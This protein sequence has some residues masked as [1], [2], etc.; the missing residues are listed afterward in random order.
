M[1]TNHLQL[2]NLI[3]NESD[4]KG[5]G[6]KRAKMVVEA[7]EADIYERLDSCD[8]QRFLP[9]LSLPLAINLICGW[10]MHR[11]KAEITSF[12]DR[13]GIEANLAPPIFKK[14]GAG[15]LKLIEK[16]PY[17]LL[18][19]LGWPKVDSI[20][21]SMGLKDHGCRLVGAVEQCMYVEYENQKNTWVSS[22]KLTGAVARL[23][24]TKSDRAEVAVEL[25]A[26]TKAV[27]E[28]QRGFQL[29][30]AFYFE[31]RCEKWILDRLGGPLKNEKKIEAEIERF[32]ARNKSQLTW[33]QRLAVQNAIKYGFS[34]YFG[35]AGVGKTHT[36][37]AL[38]ECG[39]RITGKKI[40]MMALAAKAC[41]KMAQ[42]ANR[43]AI[44]VAKCLH[45]YASSD[46]IDSIVIVDEASMLSLSD[47]YHL[48]AKM[49]ESA[50]MVLLGDS[51]QIPSINAGTVL[52]S[53]ASSRAVPAVELTIAQRQSEET[54]IPGVLK[55]VRV[56]RLPRLPRYTRGESTGIF[57]TTAE[58]GEAIQSAV[59]KVFDDFEGHVQVISPLAEG[60]AGAL[61]LNKAIHQHV[62]GTG[63]WCIGTPVIF[64][65]NMLSEIGG[66][67]LVNGLMGS[68]VQILQ[69]RPELPYSPYLQINFDDSLVALTR[70][71]VERYLEKAYALTV[72][73]AQGSDWANVIA[74]IVK[75]HF[76]VD[77]SM[78]Y[79]AI[80]R[81]KQCC[82]IIVSDMIDLRKAVEKEPFFKTRE[83]RFMSAILPSHTR[84]ETQIPLLT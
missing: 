19:V 3:A 9:I 75:H 69:H 13:H 61:G 33:E 21:L 52:Y 74:V 63:E 48:T 12:L 50:S 70:E 58:N 14:F 46:L 10:Q 24:G 80:S 17:R 2:I 67:E 78:V 39:E 60:Q 43:P 18:A 35:G 30:G 71:E 4:F 68:V 20:G 41:R 25:A 37:K 29:P 44:T 32:E 56:G 26:E 34:V 49:P 38:V 55:E 79:T 45:H 77:R 65:K 73:K 1:S 8:A 64:T 27:V 54:G 6:L 72:H 82:V 16:N 53:L 57:I 66:I 42:A 7:F 22:E 47:F 84:N 28:Y 51:A 83:N 5:F 23:L 81:C 59:L 62:H 11:E 76:L 40:V 36:L 15:S 31:R